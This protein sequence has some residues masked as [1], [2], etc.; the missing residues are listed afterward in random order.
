MA[1]V[2]IL[3]ESLETGRELSTIGRTLA[4]NIKSDLTVITWQSISNQ[5]YF[6]YGADKVLLLPSLAQE[7]PPQSYI[8]VIIEAARQD[9]PEV[10]L[11]TASLLGKEMAARIAGQLGAGLG[12]DCT[13]LR[14]IDSESALEMDRLYYGGAA[15]Q[16]VRC[17]KAPRMATVTHKSYSPATRQEGR[18]GPVIEL[19]APPASPIRVLERKPRTHTAGDIANARVVVCVGR[20]FVQ[21]GDLDL[22]RQLAETLGGEIACTRPISQEMGWLPEDVC[23]GLSAKKVKPD[24][25]IGLGISGQIQHLTGIKDAHVIVAI[26]QDVNAPI[27]AAADY[28]IAGDLYEVVPR[29][30]HSLRK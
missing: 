7:Q 5:E 25:Y 2:W 26:N 16:S 24:L 8:P 3:A 18:S 9:M 22:A 6:T 20:G 14:W 12:S 19:P 27:F 10:F 15:V 4:D 13:A 28:G 23:I 21:Q 11:F 29:L 17:S 30:L 1:G